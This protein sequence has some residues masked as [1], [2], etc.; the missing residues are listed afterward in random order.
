MDVGWQAWKVLNI[1]PVNL[2]KKT[3]VYIEKL[4]GKCDFQSEFIE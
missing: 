3:S 1:L 4:I 2:H